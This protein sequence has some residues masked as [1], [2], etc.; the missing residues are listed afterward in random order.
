[1]DEIRNTNDR[2]GANFEVFK[3]QR[4]AFPPTAMRDNIL[5]LTESQKEII[6]GITGTYT[7]KGIHWFCF[8]HLSQM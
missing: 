8:F 5:K 4:R 2:R 3:A 1:M 6:P 7:A